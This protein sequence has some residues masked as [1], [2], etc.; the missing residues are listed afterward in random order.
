M[1]LQSSIVDSLNN[2]IPLHI[3]VP[4]IIFIVTLLAAGA[5]IDSSAVKDIYEP[6]EKPTIKIEEV[7]HP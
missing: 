4:A 6:K 1:A 5:L 7:S 2:V 3:L